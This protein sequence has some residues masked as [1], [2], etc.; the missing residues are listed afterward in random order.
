MP[1]LKNKPKPSLSETYQLPR[2]LSLSSIKETLPGKYH[3]VFGNTPALRRELEL[4]EAGLALLRFCFKPRSIAE[5]SRQS[6]EGASKVRALCA[7]LAS[8]GILS[9]VGKSVNPAFSRYDRHSLFYAMNGGDASACQTRISRARV[10]LIGMGGIGNWVALNLIGAGLKEL[11]LLDFDHIELSNLTRQVL[12]DESDIGRS[13]VR[14]AARVLTRKNRQ[15]KVRAVSLRVR[16]PKSLAAHL[17]GID[18]VIL[19]ADRPEKIHDW[20]D[21]VCVRRAIPYL[22]IGYRDGTGVVGPLTVAKKTSCYQCFKPSTLKPRPRAAR[23]EALRAEFDARYQAPSF[24][25]LN[26]L[27]STIGSLEVLKYLT[28][29][30]GVESLGVELS[31]DPL[32]LETTR[33]PYPRDK[34]CWHC[35]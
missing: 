3:A 8:A 11:R 23:A 15:T 29:L 28:G 14:T 22:N 13:K 17:R 12:F 30:G 7:A 19:S 10:A 5:I 20:L 18:F 26:A 1:K 34:R 25:P 9:V 27:V 35:S 24:G 31:V 21:E 32:S 33:T 6:G 2:Y 16:D 4:D